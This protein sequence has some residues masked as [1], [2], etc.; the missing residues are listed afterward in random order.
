MG[1]L[2]DTTE[3]YLKT[4]FELE[5]DGVVPLRARIVDRLGHSG[6]TVS[7]TIARMERDDLVVV[8]ENRRLDLTELG[9]KLANEVMRKHRLAECLL[10][11]VVGLDWVDAHDEACRWEHVM[12]EMVEE[13]LPVL[14]GNPTH[15]PYGNPVPGSG[16]ANT[17]E[18][19]VEALG[20][21]RTPRRKKV[22][23]IGEPIQAD[24]SMLAS[25]EQVGVVPGA[26]IV[27][28]RVD[29]HYEITA[30]PGVESEEDRVVLP[31]YFAAHLFLT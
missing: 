27:V 30:I 8:A 31:S 13:R 11:Q 26:E 10:V 9:R 12:S 17:E 7:Q 21:E 3:M 2:I 4:I 24:R 1:D 22:S 29:D 5:E 28:Q 25:F 20:L 19:S 16:E 18:K 14:L 23:R 15:D 6:P